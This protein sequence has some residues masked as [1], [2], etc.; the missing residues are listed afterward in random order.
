MI[1]GLKLKT[2]LKAFW[3]GKMNSE[4]W[5][6]FDYKIFFKVW[7]FKIYYFQSCQILVYLA[8]LADFLGFVIYFK[9]M[10]IKCVKVRVFLTS[11]L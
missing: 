4:I 3:R 10:S 6:P 8:D 1:A 5:N 9:M 2:D 11:S 7:N